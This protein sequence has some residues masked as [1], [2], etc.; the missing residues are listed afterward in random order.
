MKHIA[1]FFI[2]IIL[3]GVAAH[4]QEFEKNI[5]TAKT[6]YGSGKLEEAHFALRQALQELDLQIGKEILKLLPTQVASLNANVPVDEVTSI[7][8]ILGT[9]IHR[10]YGEKASNMA[11]IT[12]M[13][14]SPMVAALNTFLNT[15]ILGGLMKDA[16]TKIIKVQGYKARLE[17]QVTEDGSKTGYEMQLPMGSALVIMKI[18]NCT[19]AQITTAANAIPFQ[20][21]AKLVE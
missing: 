16:N 14:N 2:S 13:S 4:A 6:A 20:Q 19:E 5:G 3:C 18:D 8:G 10:S 9:S 17:K 21:I 1:T 12:I 11:D 15:P 7:P